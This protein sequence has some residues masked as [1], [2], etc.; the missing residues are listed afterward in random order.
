MNELYESFAIEDIRALSEDESEALYCD[1]G[2]LRH[3]LVAQEAWA[4]LMPCPQPGWM[5]FDEDFVYWVEGNAGHVLRRSDGQRL[6]V[7]ALGDGGYGFATT[8]QGHLFVTDEEVLGSLR[9]RG[10]GPIHEASLV[11]VAS[12]RLTP[13]LIESFLA[14]R[15]LR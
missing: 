9:L 6:V 2:R 3:R 15:S 10:A 4:D 11:E 7:R 12:E 13:S 8:P 14:G 5:R 1:E